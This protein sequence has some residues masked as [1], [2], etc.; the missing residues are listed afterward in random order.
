M[1]PNRQ[2]SSLNLRVG[3]AVKVRN[4]EE[5]LPTLDKEGCLDSLPFMPEM[6]AY[7]GREFRVL[8]RIDKV[9]DTVDQT[10]LRRMHNA[11]ILEG[12]RC[13]GGS[14]G[15]CQAL[16]QIIWKEAWLSRVEDKRPRIWN[17]LQTRS[18]MNRNLNV[19]GEH[20]VCTRDDLLR[21]TRTADS[22]NQQ[23]FSCQATE[24][25][26]ASS[27][28]VWWDVRQYWRDLRGGN[29]SSPE[30]IRGLLFWV[31]TLILCLCSKIS[32]SCYRLL[33][34]FYDRLQRMRGG[35]PY[36][37]KWGVLEKTPRRLLNLSPG[38]LV[39][40]KSHDEILATLDKR[41]RNR[42]LWFDAE[43]VKYCGGIY[44]VLSRVEKIIDHK[45]GRM[46]NLLNDCIILEGVTIQGD[47]HRFY[48]Q[49]EYPLWREIWLERVSSRLGVD[50]HNQEREHAQESDQKLHR[51]IQDVDRG[52]IRWGGTTTFTPSFRG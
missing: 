42:G 40:V 23:R 19:R 38:E 28:L 4:L 21:L 14:H 8:K 18:A 29:V 24:I 39:R 30:M 2:D 9:N 12:V 41:N 17:S 33:L 11:V 35:E 50:S 44:R 27:P 16:C 46:I 7:C 15:G 47:Y 45:T 48:P 6:L 49:N 32:Y 13:E 43:M 5:I 37:Y 26:K 1:T 34:W 51:A 22:G 36:S 52:R 25:K 10:G 31:F 3:D 20:P